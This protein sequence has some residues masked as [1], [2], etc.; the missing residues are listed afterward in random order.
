MTNTQNLLEAAQAALDRIP[1]LERDLEARAAKI[2][3]LEAE[4]AKRPAPE[5]VAAETAQLSADLEAKRRE[6]DDDI[7][8]RL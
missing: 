3:D 8:N 6:A 7:G 5:T 1:F 4:L 2:A